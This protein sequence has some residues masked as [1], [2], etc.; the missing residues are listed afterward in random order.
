MNWHA[1]YTKAADIIGAGKTVSSE[2]LATVCATQEG[3]KAGSQ[4]ATDYTGIRGTDGK[5]TRNP[6]Q[7]SWNL[8]Y[9]VLFVSAG[10]G[11]FTVLPVNER[12]AATSGGRG[13]STPKSKEQLIAELKALGVDITKVK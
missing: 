11:S 4:G 10:R 13:N 12:I 2:Q 1:I 8:R 3:Y 9:P 5:V 7:K 6:N